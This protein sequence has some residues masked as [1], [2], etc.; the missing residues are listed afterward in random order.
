M[1]PN[2]RIGADGRIPREARDM[3]QG[4]S[5]A[6]GGRVRPGPKAGDALHQ[7]NGREGKRHREQSALLSKSHAARNIGRTG[8]NI[9]ARG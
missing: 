1:R 3:A 8:P 2:E 4:S 5:R 9:N 6:Q 7:R